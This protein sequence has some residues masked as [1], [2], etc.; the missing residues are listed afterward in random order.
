MMPGKPILKDLHLGG[1][2]P[3]F[4]SPYNLELL[5]RGISEHC[6]IA[7]DA[8]FGFEGHPNNT[9]FEHL[10]TMYKLG[11][12]RVSFGIQDFDEKVQRLINR[13][14]PYQN[15]VKVTESAREIG[16]ESIN[17]D[18][19]Y[20]LPGQRISSIS[21]TLEKTIQLKPNR[22]ALYG[23][24]H[25]PWLKPAQK[26]FEKHLPS[27]EKR[28]LIYQFSKSMFGMAGYKDIG[29][30]HFALPGDKMYE[31]AENGSLHRNFMGYSTQSTNLL[32]GLGVSA[33]SDL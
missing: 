18:L 9:T 31:A 33:I 22:I 11:F 23:Y 16:Y 14:Q 7:E 25:I 15:V 3:T 10:Q 19:V 24:A 20:G 6:L 1:G 12:Q 5:I 27:A 30:D 29:M 8:E 26:S 28:A 32:I 17:F 13:T 21:D 2:T 4:F